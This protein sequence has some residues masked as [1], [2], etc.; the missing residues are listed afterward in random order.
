MCLKAN[1]IDVKWIQ[2]TFILNGMVIHMGSV[3]KKGGKVIW[4]PMATYID[5][6]NKSKHYLY[7]RDPTILKNLY[8]HNVYIDFFPL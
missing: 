1:N 5:Q 2:L 8:V 3:P 4:W 6:K 7:H